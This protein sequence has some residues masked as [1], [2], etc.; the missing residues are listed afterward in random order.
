MT[1]PRRAVLARLGKALAL[2]LFAAAMLTSCANMVGPRDV[3]LP[4]EKLQKSLD[5]RFPLQ[6]RA[7][8]VFEI[9][10]SNPQ[11]NTLLDNDRIAL[12]TDLNVA[13]ILTRQS[14]NGKLAL[15]GRLV[16]DRQRNAVFL[17]DAQVDRFAI[18]GVGEGQQRQIAAA[19]N[20]LVDKLLRDVPIYSL[21]PDELRY[22]GVQFTPTTI[23]TTPTAL[24]V[25]VE[26]VK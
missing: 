1:N 4:L 2:P 10:L 15:S 26:P 12:S 19:A 13:P 17:S 21:R 7:L 25:R 23:R 8:G 3:E 11:L 24:V 6:H 20:V 18:D 14:W 9:Q 5:K 16:V 22:A